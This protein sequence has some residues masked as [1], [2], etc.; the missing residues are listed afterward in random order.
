M[1]KLNI[2]AVAALPLAAQA[3]VPV[4]PSHAITIANKPA[5]VATH[6]FAEDDNKASEAVFQGL[7]EESVDED[8]TFVKAESLGRGAAKVRVHACF[9]DLGILHITVRIDYL[10]SFSICRTFQYTTF[11]SYK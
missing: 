8:V 1:T 2:L 3:F 9:S 11:K 6:L 10:P 7:D 4:A 5:F